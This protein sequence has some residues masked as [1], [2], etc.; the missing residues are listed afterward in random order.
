MS[1]VVCD[2]TRC[3]GCLACVA[4]CLDA[5]YKETDTDAVPMRIYRE[6]V[7]E[8]TG[9]TAYKTASCLQCEDA[10]C[11]KACRQKALYRNAYGAVCV[12]RAACIGCRNCAAACENDMI[13]FDKEGKAVKCNGCEERVKK[14]LQPACVKVCASDALTVE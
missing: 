3:T 14:G 8:R 7:S 13:R 5:H 4:A 12:D 6:E 10:A 9:M 11:M 2:R 1:R